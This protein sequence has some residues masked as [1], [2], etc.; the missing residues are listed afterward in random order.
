MLEAPKMAV[1]LLVARNAGLPPNQV[2][3]MALTASLIP[4]PLVVS[5]LVTSQLAQN[6][7][8]AI[9]ADT[10]PPLPP[11]PPPS[12]VVAALGGGERVRRQGQAPP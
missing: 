11:A 6:Q 5:W 2:I 3:P 4:G 9:A 8:A 12:Q 10:P 7:A 1:G